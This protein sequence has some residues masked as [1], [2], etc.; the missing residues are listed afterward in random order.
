M[1]RNVQHAATP[2]FEPLESRVL[3]S[4][5]LAVIPPTL[6]GE[7]VPAGQAIHVNLND[8][9][10]EKQQES[11]SILA[12]EAL[13]GDGT[14]GQFDTTYNS[15]TDGLLVTLLDLSDATPPTIDSVSDTPPAVPLG[16]SFQF[17][18]TVSDTGGSGLNSVQLQR[19][20]DLNTWQFIVQNSAS[21]D[22][23]V[24]GYLSDTPPA[25]GDWWYRIQVFD[26]AGNSTIQTPPLHV[27]VNPPDITPPTPN[28][29]D[30]AVMPHPTSATSM[31]MAAM[32][33]TDANGVEY[34]F[35]E[36]N[37]NPGAT[38]SGWQDSSVYEDTGL[39]PSTT[40]VY[41]VKTRD[42]SPNH[43]ETD[44]SESAASGRSTDADSHA[45]G[46]ESEHLGATTPYADAGPD[47]LG[48]GHGGERGGRY[49]RRGVLLPRDQ[50]QSGGDGQRLAGQQYV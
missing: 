43:N 34:Y 8:Q 29:S 30:W 10:P 22:G 41:Q 36:I 1:A 13:P 19:T 37:G 6:A 27:V 16:G 46:P 40:Y 42:K 38:E 25:E 12:L 49:Q 5:D 18:Y 20:N 35:H 14:S 17:P 28:P 21:G 32:T 11:A 26:T 33:A 3:L 47:W 31:Q 4:A 48:L 50:R 44:F 45:A 23:P 24:T 9:A 15:G 39:R 7:A 2:S